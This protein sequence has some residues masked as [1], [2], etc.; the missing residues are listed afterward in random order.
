MGSEHGGNQT[1]TFADLVAP[2]EP[3]VPFAR[4]LV[5]GGTQDAL[6]LHLHQHGMDGAFVLCGVQTHGTG[7][8]GEGLGTLLD[9]DATGEDPHR[10]GQD[11][12]DVEGHWVGSLA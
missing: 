1:V 2:D 12:G 5:A 11:G 9:Q 7:Q 4:L 6:L 10:Q 3:Q 8:L